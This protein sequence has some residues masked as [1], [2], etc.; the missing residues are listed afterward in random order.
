MQWLANFNG[1]SLEKEE[2]F[3]FLQTIID[4]VGIG[5]I[6]FQPDGTVELFNNAAKR[7]LKVTALRNIESLDHIDSKLVETLRNISPGDNRLVKL[8]Q[9]GDLLQLSIYATG[10]VFETA[11]IAFSRHAE[12][13]E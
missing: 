4:H 6:A 5:L 10:F 8:Q 12:H 13:T 2:H 1:P 7:L 9:D 3:R 11:T